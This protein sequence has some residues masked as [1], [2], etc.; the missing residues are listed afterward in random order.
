MTMPNDRAKTELAKEPSL[1]E[2]APPPWKIRDEFESLIAGDLLGPAQGEHEIL[3]REVEYVT[4]TSRECWRRK[5]RLPAIRNDRKQPR[6][7]HNV[8]GFRRYGK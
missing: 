5:T 7:R 8:G 4:G 6:G 2:P 3:P 1:F